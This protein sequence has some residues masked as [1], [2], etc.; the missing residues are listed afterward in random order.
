MSNTEE[1]LEDH[2]SNWKL[3]NTE[4]DYQWDKNLFNFSFIMDNVEVRFPFFIQST[5]TTTSTINWYNV[6]RRTTLREH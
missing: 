5:P 6:N 4:C 1:F 3:C 2:K